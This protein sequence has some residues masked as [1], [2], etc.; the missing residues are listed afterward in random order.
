M[1]VHSFGPWTLGL[2]LLFV[3]LTAEWTWH[4]QNPG[5]GEFVWGLGNSPFERVGSHWR[6]R[7]IPMK[8][9][10]QSG[11]DGCSRCDLPLRLSLG[12][13]TWKH[14]RQPSVSV[15]YSLD[16]SHQGREA[17]E[18]P[19]PSSLSGFFGNPVGKQN[20]NGGWGGEQNRPTCC[21]G[22]D[23]LSIAF[24]CSVGAKSQWLT[25]TMPLSGYRTAD[26]R[27]GG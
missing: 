17:K 1:L 3:L 4:L 16:F 14:S 19:G 11:Q 9:N 7:I 21:P 2:P 12:M 6:T 15:L 10:H 24:L 25:Q 13:G 22:M 5:V 8:L 20:C 26:C 18:F 23:R 27:A